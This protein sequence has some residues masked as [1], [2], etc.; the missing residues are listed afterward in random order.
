MGGG[1]RAQ[2]LSYGHFVLSIGRSVQRD[3]LSWSA[4]IKA[5]W[6]IGVESMPILLVIAGFIGSNLSLQGHAAFAPLGAQRML[7]MFVSL[8]GVRELAP[9][10]AGSMVAA[11]A[12]TQMA[13]QLG[14]MRIQEQ[15]DALEVMAVDPLSHLVA[16]RLAGIMLALPA[17]VI[18]STFT[19]IAAAYAAAVHQLGVGGATFLRFAADGV[20]PIDF[21]YGEVKG[22]VFGAVICT[23]SCWYGFHCGNGPE[24]V[25]R[26][27]NQAVVTSAVLCVVLNYVLS[28]VMYG[29]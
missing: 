19:M 15:L 7:G 26:A 1:L 3:G 16:P 2:L 11:K 9:I 17:L 20:R 10:I 25:G 28:E 18:V 23:V 12:G 5:A 29:G 27:T 14:V 8:A 22:A 4:S 6:D 13:S 21:A 24:G